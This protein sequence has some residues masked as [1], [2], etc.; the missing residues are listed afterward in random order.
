MQWAV[1]KL[2]WNLG[3]TTN[4]RGGPQCQLEEDTFQLYRIHAMIFFSP[5]AIQISNFIKIGYNLIFNW[6]L[7]VKKRCKE[8]LKYLFNCF[9]NE[10]QQC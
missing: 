4:M 5:L 9:S 1:S 7:V 8:G 3:N 6:E 10:H 2:Y